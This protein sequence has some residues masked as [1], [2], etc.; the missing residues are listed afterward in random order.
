MRWWSPAHD[1]LLAKL[2][3]EKQW[4]WDDYI[5]FAVEAMTPLTV[6]ENWSN[7]PY[8][9][10]D[11]IRRQAL[12]YFARA[13]A[14]KLGL[15]EAIRAPLVKICPLCDKR[16]L[17]NSLPS[18][19]ARALGGTHLD[20]CAPCLADCTFQGVGD[21][22]MAKD[23]VLIYVRDLVDALKRIPQQDFAIGRPDDIAALD[24]SERLTVLQVL[25]RRPTT[26]RIREVCGSWFN[27]LVEAGVLEKGTRRTMRG[28]Q[29]LA[30]DGHVCLS[31]GEKTIDD[32]L[33]MHGVA[34]EREPRYPEGQFRADFIARGSFIEYLG[35]AGDPEYDAKTRIKKKLCAAHSIPLILVYPRDLAS[36][37]RLTSK[38]APIIAETSE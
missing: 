25:K 8:T 10:G 15:T 19:V 14:V 27:A 16:F 21:P 24:L 30:R 34:H 7:D 9:G 6:L 23:N 5:H 12:L 20:Y 3:E 36:V 33:H 11:F 29:C 28:T 13:R 31:L 22:R 26:K 17:E 38:M 2:I 18:P 4:Y 32:Y 1:A 35:L 37:T